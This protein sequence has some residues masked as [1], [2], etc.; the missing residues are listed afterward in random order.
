MTLIDKIEGEVNLKDLGVKADELVVTLDPNGPFNAIEKALRV[1]NILRRPES[2][3]LDPDKVTNK[4]REFYQ[5]MKRTFYKTYNTFSCPFNKYELA[6]MNARGFYPICMAPELG[7]TDHVDPLIAALL[8]RDNE[9]LK[10]R[11]REN[12]N[13]QNVVWGFYQQLLYP[14]PELSKE[15]YAWFNKVDPSRRLTSRE[16]MTLTGY[17]IAGLDMQARTGLRFDQF[18]TG[19]RVNLS[20]NRPIETVIVR[21][22]ILGQQDKRPLVT[23]YRVINF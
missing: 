19:T 12:S 20:P 3:Y 4:W 8:G 22:F 10:K 6:S 14:H 11:W 17:L 13:R 5:E 21:P 23:G 16:I 7:S 2:D 9:E 1:R 15:G 18:G